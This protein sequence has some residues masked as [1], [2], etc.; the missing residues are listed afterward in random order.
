MWVAADIV[1]PQQHSPG[2]L[3][4]FEGPLQG[5]ER[6]RKREGKIQ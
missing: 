5:G 6:Q 4:G 3:A 1:P 2:L